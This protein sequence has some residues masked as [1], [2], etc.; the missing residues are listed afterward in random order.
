MAKRQKD[1]ESQRGP[2]ERPKGPPPDWT[3]NAVFAGLAVLIVLA[4]FGWTETRRLRGDVQ[5][6]LDRLDTTVA[7]LST[8]VAD[9][10]KPAA[11]PPR[12]GPDP[13]K[14]Y[15]VKTAG[16]PAEGPPSAPITIAEF[17]DFQ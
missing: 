14:V 17:S 15:T 5:T 6:R 4:A 12:Q 16:S 11:A 8:K 1:P 13:N 3:R 10:A 7:Q 2:Q 9:V